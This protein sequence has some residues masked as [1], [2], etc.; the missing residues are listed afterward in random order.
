[1]AYSTK[2]M[3]MNSQSKNILNTRIFL[4]LNRQENK[5]IQPGPGKQC[6]YE[7][8]WKCTTNV[9]N[10]FL[11]RKFGIGYIHQTS[12]SHLTISTVSQ[13]PIYTV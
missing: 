3:D 9:S 2:D 1:M 11:Q 10:E 13:L 7:K 4:A 6:S 5:N 8:T 12:F